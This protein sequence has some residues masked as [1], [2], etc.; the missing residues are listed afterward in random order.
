VA[1]HTNHIIVQTSSTNQS[2]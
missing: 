2:N 1:T